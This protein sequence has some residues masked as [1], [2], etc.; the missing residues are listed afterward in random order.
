MIFPRLRFKDKKGLDFPGW[1][2]KSLKDVCQRIMD[3]THFSPKSKGG[4][5]RYLTSKNIRNTGVDLTDCSYISEE[6]HQEIYKKCPVKHGDI[7]L[8]KD[9]ANTGNCCLNT[10]QEEFSLLSSVAVLNVKEDLHSNLFLL[11]LLQS[12]NGVNE[13]SNAMAG[14][15]ISRITLEKINKFRFHFPVF[16]EQTKIANFL[17]AIDEKIAQLTQKCDL[18]AQY[19]KGVMQQIFSRE[20][21]F[22]DEDG[23]DFPGWEETT[24][25]A[26][27]MFLR[28][29]SL[30]KSDISP[31]GKFECV[32][33]GELFTNY[34]EIISSVISK[35]DLTKTVKSEFGDILMPSSDVTPVGLAKAS[36]ILKAGVVL[37]GDINIIRLKDEIAPVFISYLLNFYKN[38]IIELV[39]GTTVKHIYI[40]DIKTIELTIPR[41]SKEQTKI[42]NFLIAIDEKIT[43]TKTQLSAVK[44]YKQG[45]LQQMFV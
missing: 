20:L 37:G 42:A 40:K 10:L 15:A 27:A 45:L 32:H 36:C 19:K 3:G 41:S 9:G 33:Y 18:L 17:S 39:T 26:I 6:E 16:Q 29:G 23:Q 38:K 1:E 2:E 14:Q 12:R 8:T 34:S 13:I 7:L 25:G 24:L 22:K 5:R 28:G 35:T 4:L 44:Q 11:Q 21:R 30:S 43:K 31:D